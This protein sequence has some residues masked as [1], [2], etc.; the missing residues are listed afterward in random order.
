[1]CV[2]IHKIALKSMFF[3]SLSSPTLHLW[4]QPSWV[5]LKF[6]TTCNETIHHFLR[7]KYQNEETNAAIFGFE[8]HLQQIEHKMH[9]KGK[10]VFSRYLEQGSELGVEV[11][12]RLQQRVLGGGGAQRFEETVGSVDE[13]LRSFWQWPRGCQGRS[14]TRERCHC[15]DF[16]DNLERGVRERG[17]IWDN[18]L[19]FFLHG[20]F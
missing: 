20:K 3:F 19:L 18:V 7:A 13:G 16:A 5:I 11:E 17:R 12:E 10:K 14:W 6:S 1:M 15:S 9:L 2:R 8:T 4:S